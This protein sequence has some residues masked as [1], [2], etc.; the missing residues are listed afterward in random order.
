M[1]YFALDNGWNCAVLQIESECEYGI[2]V[3]HTVECEYTRPGIRND[4]ICTTQQW[5]GLN[6][7][8]QMKINPKAA[9]VTLIFFL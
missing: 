2:I 6:V 1:V 9:L 7:S 4:L 8:L 3:V 5:N